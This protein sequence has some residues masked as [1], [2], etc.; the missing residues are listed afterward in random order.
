MV[1]RDSSIPSP[2]TPL[3]V[4]DCYTVLACPCKQPLHT[5][6]FYITSMI[7]H[8][9]DSV[10]FALA[11]WPYWLANLSKCVWVPVDQTGISKCDKGRSYTAGSGQA[12]RGTVFF[13]VRTTGR[14]QPPGTSQTWDVYPLLR[15]AVNCASTLLSYDVVTD[16]EQPDDIFSKRNHIIKRYKS[17]KQVDAFNC[18]VQV[19]HCK[20]L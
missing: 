15:E 8:S 17:Y 2:C 4:V 9:M 12:N 16:S 13:M 19:P 10:T 20:S 11:C 6:A 7:L 3:H 1:E 5:L 14:G 18:F